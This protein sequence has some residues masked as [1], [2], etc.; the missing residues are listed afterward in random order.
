M[1]KGVIINFYT[2]VTFIAHPSGRFLCMYSKNTLAVAPV[3]CCNWKLKMDL[4]WSRF[5]LHSHGLLILLNSNSC[6]QTGKNL[7]KSVQI[8]KNY[9]CTY[10]AMQFFPNYWFLRY[11]QFMLQVAIRLL[12]TL[13]L[14]ICGIFSQIVT[15]HKICEK[16]YIAKISTCTI[17]VCYYISCKSENILIHKVLLK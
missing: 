5:Y 10:F 13:N 9:N 6:T 12:L 11:F 8:T 3:N 7:T 17:T 16:K 15:D 2:L 4:V 1:I 14:Y